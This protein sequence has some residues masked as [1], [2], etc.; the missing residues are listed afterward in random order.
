MKESL[1][2]EIKPIRQPEVLCQEMGDEV[3]LYPL[4]GEAVHV[5][6]RTALAILELCD[7]EHSYA[8][9]E[10]AIRLRFVIRDP[11]ADIAADVSNALQQL[12][13]K[14]LVTTS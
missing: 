5:L 6:N 2:Q 4:D 10:Q 8:Q 9:I 12:L 7:G 11:Q 14:G 13:E 1:M 3:V